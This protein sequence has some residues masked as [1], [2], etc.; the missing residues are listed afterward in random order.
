[1]P[2][3]VSMLSVLGMLL[4]SP[5]KGVR[6]LSSLNCDMPGTW[7]RTA[8]MCGL[9]SRAVGNVPNVR[10]GE[11]DSMLCMSCGLVILESTSPKDP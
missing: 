11:P 7:D 2:E 3:S 5:L 9:A 8:L 10:S 4:G 1:M 6:V